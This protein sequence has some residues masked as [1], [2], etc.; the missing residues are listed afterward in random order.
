MKMKL[1]GLALLGATATASQAALITGTNFDSRTLSGNEMQDLVWTTDDPNGAQ[2][3]T[4]TTI[5]TNA[6][7]F[8]NSG[9]GGSATQFTPNQNLHS[10]AGFWTA[11]FDITVAAGFVADLT[12]ISFVYDTLNSSGGFQNGGQIRE[13]LF[14]ITINGNA[15]GSQQGGDTDGVLRNTPATFTENL[16]LAAGT[17]TIVI[18]ADGSG[19]GVFGSI[20]DL[21]INGSVNTASIPEPSISALLGLGGMALIIRRRK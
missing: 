20:D 15:Y 5:V 9:G 1:L 7:N 14:D 3:T 12:D 11:T 18:T 16:Q 2:V 10:G 6:A 17:H 13:V 21:A 4:D 8:L 19:L